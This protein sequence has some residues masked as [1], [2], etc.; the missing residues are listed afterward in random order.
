MTPP[1]IYCT[2]DLKPRPW[3][4]QR[5]HEDALNIACSFV[6]ITFLIVAL[7]FVSRAA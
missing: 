3:W 5:K 4:R 7:A 2:A 6:L 1:R